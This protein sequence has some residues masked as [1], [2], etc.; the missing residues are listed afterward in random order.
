[1]IVWALL[2][3]LVAGDAQRAWPS[4]AIDT[5]PAAV[6]PVAIVNGVT[7]KSD[8]L[9]A[10]VGQLLPLESFHQNVSADKMASLRQRALVQV[11]DEE[12]QYQDGVKSGLTVTDAAVKTALDQAVARYP[13]RKAFDA[14]LVRSGATIADMRRELRR[15][16]VISRIHELQVTARCVVDRA[17]AERFFHEH[18]ER[19]VEPERLHIR[20]ITLGVDPSSGPSG[21]S[22]ARVRAEEVR[23]QLAGGAAFE[24]LAKKY[25]TDPSGQKGGDMGLVHRGSLSQGFETVAA[26]LPVGQPS[27]VVETIYGYH[28][29]QVT[30]ILAP[31]ARSFADVGARLQQDLTGERCAA[32]SDAWTARLRSA[33]TIAYPQ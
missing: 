31:Q 15:R 25:S 12:L 7:L 4:H 16:L 24:D 27:P 8:R 30:E 11:V 2:L 14:A 1:M 26:S 6:R 29:I 17:E 5:V 3:T 19:F 28:V 33:A 23:S 9:E 21:W 10:A 20:A 18:P 13:N 32:A 22:A